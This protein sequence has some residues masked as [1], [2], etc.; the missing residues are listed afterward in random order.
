MK[1]TRTNKSI[2]SLVAGLSFAVSGYAQSTKNISVS[3]FSGITISSGIDLYINQTGTESVKLV[4]DNDLIE[5]VVVEKEGNNIRIHYEEGF[6]WSSI[7]SK[8]TVKAYVTVKELKALTASGGSDV[9]TQNT[10]KSSQMDLRASGGSDI[11]MSLVCSDIKI[12]SSGGSDI[13]LKGSAEN[14]TLSTS[15]GSDVN[16]LGFPVNYAKVTASGGSDANVY[17]NKALEAS[18]SGGS[19]VHYK[20]DASYK[21]TSSSKSG[22]VTR[23]K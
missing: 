13:D 4:G 10:I 14:M 15:G 16:A 1:L 8:K 3:N 22:D 5:S 7:F 18:A 19:D 23:I 17:V 20:G 9:Y 2:L 11:K 21:K 12:Q 6:R